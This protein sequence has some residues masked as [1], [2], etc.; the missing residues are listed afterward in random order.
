MIISRA[1]DSISVDMSGTTIT[2]ATPVTIQAVVPAGASQMQAYNGGTKPIKLLAGP[3]GATAIPLIL[4]PGVQTP[5]MAIEG[6]IGVNHVLKAQS[7]GAD[8]TTG[9]LILN[10]F[11]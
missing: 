6:Q 4:A 2:A 5:V 7:I 1:V 10:F 9:F 3:T 11:G 8:N